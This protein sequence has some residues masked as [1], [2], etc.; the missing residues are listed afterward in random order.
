MEMRIVA[1]EPQLAW[2]VLSGSIDAVGVAVV[3]RDFLDLCGRLE[4]GLIVDLSWAKSLTSVG[5]TMLLSGKKALE[6]RGLKMVLFRPSVLVDLVLKNMR[7][8][9]I[10]EIVHDEGQAREIV[11]AG[12]GSIPP[13]H[14]P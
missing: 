2:L 11:S 3:Q 13:R 9:T 8:Q 4:K 6:D 14:R 7:L 10:F 5:V 12:R 1:D